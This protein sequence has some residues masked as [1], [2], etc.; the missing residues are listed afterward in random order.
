MDTMAHVLHYPQKPLATTRAMDHMH[1][2][3]L[4]SGI[5]CI[6]GIACYTGYNQEDSLI[7]NQSSIDRGL[8][9]SS[10]FRTYNAKAKCRPGAY[11]PLTDEAFEKPGMD[12]NEKKR[13]SY[14]KLGPDGLAEPGQRISN[15]DVLIGKTVPYAIK[16]PDAQRTTMARKDD[17]TAMRSNESGI[18][19]RVMLS[20]DQDGNK[21]SKVRIRIPPTCPL[22]TNPTLH[23]TLLHPTLLYPTLYTFM[24]CT[25]HP[26]L[27]YPTLL[28]PIPTLYPPG[29][30]S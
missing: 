1:F 16:G 13:G 11:D 26:T 5:N 14:D 10:F 18:V 3:E 6:V 25:L 9:R 7:M 8:F 4:P 22:S 20:T 24:H 2:R 15:D 21:F 28:Y 17:S 12:V 19:D 27:Q 23:P 29:A 30:H